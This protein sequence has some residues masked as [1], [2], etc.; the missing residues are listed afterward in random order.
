MTL[1]A[2]TQRAVRELWMTGARYG[3]EVIPKPGAD[4]LEDDDLLSPQ[5]S[6]TVELAGVP[7]I[8]V[9]LFTDLSDY[10]TVDDM[11]EFEVP[12]HD[13]VAGVDS[14]LAGNAHMRREGGT[15]WNTFRALL[16]APLVPYV[17]FDRCVVVVT[18]PGGAIY[19]QAVPPALGGN[20]WLSTLPST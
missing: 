14:I 1:S 6:T 9:R 8:T 16:L 19:E 17:A 15:R 11:T 10:V 5:D 4:P 3:R 20:P 7:V 2:G 18:V 13:T 12:R